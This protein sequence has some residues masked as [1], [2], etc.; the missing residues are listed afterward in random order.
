MSNTDKETEANVIL[1]TLPAKDGPILECYKEL[2]QRLEA[3]S[4]YNPLFL[5]DI[6]STNRYDHRQWL[7]EL[8]LPFS[9]MVYKYAHGKH[10]GTAVFAWKLPSDASVDQTVV[11]RIF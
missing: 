7:A 1:V 4:L 11:S 3:L 10:L 5:N 8:Q 2:Y 9:V 6:A